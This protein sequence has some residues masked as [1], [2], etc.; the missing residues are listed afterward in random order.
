MSACLHQPR[1]VS[2]LTPTRGPIRNTAAFNDNSG[3]CSRASSTSRTDRSRSSRG[4]FLGAG[5]YPPSCGIR[6]SSKPGA[7][8][9]VAGL[10]RQLDG[11]EMSDDVESYR[12]IVGHAGDGLGPSK[13]SVTGLGR[14]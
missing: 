9:G 3:S 13:A 14:R 2:L 6:A 4:Y 7:L 5:I 1:N 8:Q 11:E 10:P 12:M